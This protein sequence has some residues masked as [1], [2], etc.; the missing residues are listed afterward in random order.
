MRKFS[1]AQG[2]ETYDAPRGL[3]SETG[4][5][6]RGKWNREGRQA[7]RRRPGGFTDRSAE[8]T[9]PARE[10]GPSTGNRQGRGEDPGDVLP[11]RP[12]LRPPEPAPLR[13]HRRRVEKRGG[14]PP[15]RRAP[16]RCILDL[17][18]GTGDLALAVAKR[19]GGRARVVAADFTFEMLALGQEK[20]RRRGAP[21]PE[22]G[23]DGLRLPFPDADVRRRHRRLRREE[24]RGPRPRA[25]R[26]LP[27]PEARRAAR[28]PRVH[29][30]A[31]RAR[32]PRSSAST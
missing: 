20:F 1:L 28:R 12:A 3:S 7:A 23:A 21:I 26:A 13:R 16:A 27:G 29:A 19:S 8:A 5:T 24:L 4:Q 2:R 25:P 32:S 11:D 15:R 10:R 18:S 14:P 9:V 31:D 6:E 30:G 22:A 17:C